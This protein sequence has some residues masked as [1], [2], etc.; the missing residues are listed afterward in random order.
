MFLIDSLNRSL[1][2]KL[3]LTLLLITILPIFTLGLINYNNEKD[4]MTEQ[5]FLFNKALANDL[6]VKIDYYIQKKMNQIDYLASESYLTRDD[7]LSFQELYQGFEL[8]YLLNQSGVIEAISEGGLE[9]KSNYYGCL[10]YTSPS[11]RD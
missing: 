4:L 8:V 2:K 3:I 7:L 1:K 6:G 11:P 5:V 9:V 10:L